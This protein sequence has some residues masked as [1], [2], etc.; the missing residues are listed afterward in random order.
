MIR[1]IEPKVDERGVLEPRQRC[2]ASCKRRTTCEQIS[3]A[4]HDTRVDAPGDQRTLDALAAMYFVCNEYESMFINYP[5]TVESITTDSAHTLKMD[6]TGRFAC[7]E[8]NAEGY[9]DQQHLAIYLGDLPLSIV[10]AFDQRHGTLVNRFMVNPAFYVI[11]AGRVFYGM[12]CR[13]KFID[14]LE[15]LLTINDGDC[16]EG[17]FAAARLQ[18]GENS[19]VTKPPVSK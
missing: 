16:P 4:L 6:N 9:D 2:C 19:A 10:S 14:T 13:W 3:T 11:N 7:I 12:N 17:Y 15:D 8:L 1:Q 18:L 5:I